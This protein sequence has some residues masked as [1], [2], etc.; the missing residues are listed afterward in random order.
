MPMVF[1]CVGFSPPS[2]LSLHPS[3]WWDR[4]TCGVGWRRRSWVFLPLLDD[5]GAS[6][7][8]VQEEERNSHAAQRVE[9]L[10]RCRRHWPLVCQQAAVAIIDLE[11]DLYMPVATAASDFVGS[12][13]QEDPSSF[14]GAFWRQLSLSEPGVDIKH[15]QSLSIRLWDLGAWWTDRPKPHETFHRF[16]CLRCVPV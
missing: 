3:P 13:L 6:R 5:R 9:E 14:F 10:L 15:L 1:V 11:G 12:G 8:L 2:S 4:V 7:R 16:S